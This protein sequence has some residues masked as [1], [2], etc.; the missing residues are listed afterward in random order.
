MDPDPV[1]DEELLARAATEPAA[2]EPLV[3]RHSVALHGYLAR[4]APA[5]ADDLLSEVW[6]QAFAHRHT[7]DAARGAARAWLFGVARNVLARHWQRIARDPGPPPTEEQAASDPWQAV[8]QRLDAVAAGPLIHRKLTELPAIERELL[9]LVAWEGLT[10]TEAAAVVGIPA[11]TARSRLHRAR[12]RLR[13]HLSNGTL[14][15]LTGELA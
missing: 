10:P 11:G 4:R 5:A 15:T 8:D 3:A 1:A 6:L 7:F 2:F 9:L 13:A 14:N 12:A